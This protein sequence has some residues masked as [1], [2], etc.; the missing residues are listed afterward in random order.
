MLSSQTSSHQRQDDQ[1][2]AKMGTLYFGFGRPCDYLTKLFTGLSIFIFIVGN[3]LRALDEVVQ[4]FVGLI[5]VFLTITM[6]H[7]AIIL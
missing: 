7:L 2:M 3:F 1:V 4:F 6:R 5:G